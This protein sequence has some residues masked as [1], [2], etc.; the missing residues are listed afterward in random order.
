[1]CTL[2]AR[3]TGPRCINCGKPTGR[4][5][6]PNVCLFCAVFKG[7]CADFVYEG[8]EQN[9]RG[10]ID[11]PRVKV[12]TKWSDLHDCWQVVVTI[13]SAEGVRTLREQFQSKAVLEIMKEC[14]EDEDGLY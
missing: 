7:D 13:H 3:S 14:G 11:K 10:D 8:C 9:C 2:G 12:T 1:M 4:P 5:D 6:N